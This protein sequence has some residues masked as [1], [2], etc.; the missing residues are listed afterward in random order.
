M[1]GWISLHKK[2]RKHWLWDNPIYFRAWVDMLMMANYKLEK[3]A[4]KDKIITIKLNI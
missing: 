4:Y 3:K 1:N 2:I